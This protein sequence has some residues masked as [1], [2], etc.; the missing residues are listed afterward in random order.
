MD[1]VADFDSRLKEALKKKI[2]VHI[3]P[4]RA[5]ADLSESDKQSIINKVITT[6]RGYLVT[7]EL[8]K[9]ACCLVLLSH[10]PSRRI[11][12]SPSLLT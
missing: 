6:V 10:S 2:K 12:Q 11:I 3:P 1:L 5:W 4:D 9:V 8:V 7:E